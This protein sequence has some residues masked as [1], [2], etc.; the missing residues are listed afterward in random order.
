[1]KINH[2]GLNSSFVDK[3]VPTIP[4]ALFVFGAKLRVSVPALLLYDVEVALPIEN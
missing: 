3:K 2:N 4:D 1:M